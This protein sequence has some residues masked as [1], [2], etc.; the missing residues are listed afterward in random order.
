ML[1]ELLSPAPRLHVV[2]LE[3]SSG[4]LCLEHG[5]AFC[6][7]FWEY[8][9]CRARLD[10]HTKLAV[11]VCQRIKFLPSPP[12]PSIT[13]SSPWTCSLS[14][15]RPTTADRWLP[16]KHSSRSSLPHLKRLPLNSLFHR[17]ACVMCTRPARISVA[18]PL[19][20]LVNGGCILSSP[21]S[22][23][24]VVAGLRN[25]IEMNCFLDTVDLRHRAH[26]RQPRHP[27]TSLDTLRDL[28][29]AMFP[30]PQCHPYDQYVL[31]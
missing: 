31:Q 9:H 5:I 6:S 24:Y 1:P 23:H 18:A 25:L 11:F 19:T 10:L 30:A 27:P 8:C 12:R 21:R 14:T 29:L 16:H 13:H 22:L 3:L 7:C 15:C 28:C 17:E 2:C 26:V 20:Q 4:I